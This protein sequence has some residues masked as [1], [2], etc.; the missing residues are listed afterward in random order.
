MAKKKAKKAATPKGGAGLTVQRIDEAM[1]L[2]DFA[3]LEDI[4]R[5]SG[6]EMDELVDLEEAAGILGGVPVRTIENMIAVGKLASVVMWGR[7]LV[8]KRDV[9]GVIRGA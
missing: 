6:G 2:E 8:L 3:D 4:M 7:R 9:T 5:S 1:S